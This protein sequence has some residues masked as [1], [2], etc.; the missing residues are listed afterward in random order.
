LRFLFQDALPSYTTSAKLWLSSTRVGR[1][2]R[3]SP[4]RPE[5]PSELSVE[6][7][8]ELAVLAAETERMEREWEESWMGKKEAA[9]AI[10]KQATTDAASKK[11]VNRQEQSKGNSR[12]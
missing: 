7:E 5:G 12:C 1:F 9:A 2:L 4:P 10:T 11:G 8:R 3:V 6:E